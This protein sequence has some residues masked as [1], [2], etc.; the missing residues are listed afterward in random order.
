MATA[1]IP[2]DI[3]EPVIIFATKAPQIGPLVFDAVISDS[4]DSRL[5]VSQYP[6]E[7]GQVV[8]ENAIMQPR[9]IQLTAAVS[10]RPFDEQTDSDT[11]ASFERLS[12]WNEMILGDSPVNPQEGRTTTIS[13]NQGN[14]SRS[15]L[16]LDI[17]MKLQYYRMLVNVQGQDHSAFH[18]M[19]I[20]RIS[21][22]NTMRNEG[23]LVVKIELQEVPL[24]S[25][26]GDPRKTNDPNSEILIN[27]GRQSAS[28][29]P[30]EKVEQVLEDVKV[31]ETTNLIPAALITSSIPA[32]DQ[33]VIDDGDSIPTFDNELDPDN[34]N[35]APQAEVLPIVEP[36]P[37][38]ESY[39]FPLMQGT[40]FFSYTITVSSTTYTLEFKWSS[41]TNGFTCTIASFGIVM[42]YCIPV[43]PEVNLFRGTPLHNAVF[44]G[45][46]PLQLF[47]RG[48]D[49]T[50]E[51][52]GQSNK[53]IYGTGAVIK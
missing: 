26:G 10:N 11:Y 14:P 1:Q 41:L 18:N 19:L 16:V 20:T 12:G 32:L 35:K 9:K 49:P 37:V 52:F 30:T 17:L 46:T 45:D 5:R 53:L 25:I 42:G 27:R 21:R 22:T 29:V 50:L 34:V 4:L 48:D 40:P 23:G 38:L 3:D 24:V 13:F 2:Q 15:M 39:S 33:L 31:E 36:A 43:L 44:E 47:L 7:G 28:L 6:M 8:V 51:N